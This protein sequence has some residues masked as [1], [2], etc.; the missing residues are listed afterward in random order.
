MDNR[1]LKAHYVP[2]TNNVE[3]RTERK[4][5]SVPDDVTAAPDGIPGSA[6]A[7]REHFAAV[8]K[9]ETEK[10][11]I[12]LTSDET[13]SLMMLIERGAER[14]AAQGA[15]ASSIDVYD[16]TLRRMILDIPTTGSTD[17]SPLVEHRSIRGLTVDPCPW[18]P[19]CP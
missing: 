6:E 17:A 2:Q 14:V 13:A 1:T 9:E 18:W 19:F 7:I 5:R 15:A 11:R 12:E 10:A 16:T 3:S 8:A 4:E